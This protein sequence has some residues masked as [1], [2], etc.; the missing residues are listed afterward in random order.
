MLGY[1]Q[2]KD[3][4]WNQQK[5]KLLAAIV[6]E[7]SDDDQLVSDYEAIV[8]HQDP[9]WELYSSSQLDQVETARSKLQAYVFVLAKL[10]EDC[11]AASVTKLSQCSLPQPKP[12]IP[13]FV[14]PILPP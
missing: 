1:S 8:R 14:E 10:H 7:Y 12:S 3:A 4:L 9:R 11:K 2:A 13:D 5:L 6:A